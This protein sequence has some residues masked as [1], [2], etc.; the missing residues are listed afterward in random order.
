[1]RRM[2]KFRLFAALVCITLFG[3]V[4][5]G[6]NAGTVSP[7]SELQPVELRHDDENLT[8]PYLG[9]GTYEGAARFS[10]SRMSALAEKEL[11]EIEFYMLDKPEAC[12]VK[13]YA[14][15]TGTSPGTL[16]YSADIVR[17]LQPQAWNTHSLQ[18]PLTLSGDDL[19]ISI[20]FRHANRIRSL[21]CDPG[22]AI[23]DGDWLFSKADDEWLPLSQRSSA[24]INWN[25]R[26]L[27]LPSE[28]GCGSK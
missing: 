14:R 10:R 6:E 3:I 16:L 23:A 15:G 9:E 7:D 4:G 19:W 26:G 27:V 22:P 18:T 1:M 5:C 20:E 13:V 25:I 28:C 2:I 8:A 12:R 11:V 17:E 21:G 24:D